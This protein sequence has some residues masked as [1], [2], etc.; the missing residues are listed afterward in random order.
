MN[1][2]SMDNPWFWVIVFVGAFAAIGVLHVGLSL[3]IL[4]LGRRR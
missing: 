3:L 2:P 4:L 1:V